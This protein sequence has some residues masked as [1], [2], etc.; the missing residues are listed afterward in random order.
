MEENIKKKGFFQK[1]H[2]KAWKQVL[3]FCVS[4]AVISVMY[5]WTNT[6]L[7]NLRQQEKMKNLK[8]T[9]DYDVLYQLFTMEQNGKDISISGCVAKRNSKTQGITLM[10]HPTDGSE[11]LFAAATMENQTDALASAYK[12]AGYEMISFTAEGEKGYEEDTCY[13]V[14]LALQY[15]TEQK[16]EDNTEWIEKKEKISTGKYFYNG[17]L[18][19]Y[20]PLDYAAPEVNDAEFLEAIEQG[21]VL[22]YSMEKECWIYEYNKELYCIFNFSLFET[23]EQRPEIP[24]FIRTFQEDKLPEHRQESGTDYIAYYLT[25]ADYEQYQG[26]TY[27]L[28]KRKLPTEYAI[29]YLSTGVYQNRG[30]N[31]G[32]IWNAEVINSWTDLLEK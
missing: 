11:E 22:A 28:Y 18:Y 15:E 21:N 7:T 29:T 1:I 14:L 8:V 27:F 2:E 5:L 16:T 30:E 10:L 26:E 24:I 6:Y 13:E 3:F 25:E 23:M 12:E 20:N 32:W 17:E 31:K 9:T 19:S 4:M